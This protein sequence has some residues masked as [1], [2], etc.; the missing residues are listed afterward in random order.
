MTKRVHNYSAGP[1][2]L[3]LEVLERAKEGLPVYGDS[4]MSV[5]EF[6]HR[7]PHYSAIHEKTTATLRSLMGIPDT[8]KLL[9]LQ[10]GASL[11]FAMVPMNL[12]AAGQSADYVLTGSWS[13]KALKEAKIGGG[14]AK[15]VATSEETNFS[16]VPPESEFSHVRL[17]I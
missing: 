10:G 9:Y 2:A 3:P 1:A 15:V 8:H 16:R 11:Q 14:A 7:G 4:G 13:Q 6:S 12:R 17:N 5:M